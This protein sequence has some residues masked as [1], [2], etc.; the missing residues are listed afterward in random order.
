MLRVLRQP[1]SC[2]AATIPSHPPCA[3]KQQRLPNSQH[4]T[5]SA[6]LEVV[7]HAQHLPC[8]AGAVDKAAPLLQRRHVSHHL[9]GDVGVCR[10]RH[11][12][13]RKLSVRA[14]VWGCHVRPAQQ[15]LSSVCLPGWLCP[16]RCIHKVDCKQLYTGVP[17]AHRPGCGKLPCTAY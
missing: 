17:A 4:K 14:P 16:P 5:R 1:V 6:S 7:H 11:L 2:S 9:A 3:R 13:G 8:H 10:G 15:L 12:V